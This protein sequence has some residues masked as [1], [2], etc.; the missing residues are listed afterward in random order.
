MLRVVKV[1][2]R[3]PWTCRLVAAMGLAEQGRDFVRIEPDIARL[4]V[5]VD[6]RIPFHEP[7]LPE[8]YATQHAA[9][10]R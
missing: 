7:G 3:S 5:L 9:A 6:G 10:R 2:E 8:A 1:R 4:G